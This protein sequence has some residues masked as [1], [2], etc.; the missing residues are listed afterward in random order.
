ML[1]RSC[2]QVLEH[3]KEPDKAI[4]EIHRVLKKGGSCLLTTHMAAP[5]HGAPYDYYRF[6]PSILKELFKKFEKVEIKWMTVAEMRRRRGEFRSFYRTILDRIIQE[7]PQIY[8][9]IS[10]NRVF[11]RR[12][13]RYMNKK[14]TQK[15][16]KK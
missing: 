2:S 3:I 16:H 13:S 11:S 7:S 8:K 6:T 9:F 4:N 15:N 5:I 1:F 12:K 10:K 14:Y